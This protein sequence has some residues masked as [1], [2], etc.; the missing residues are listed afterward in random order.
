[1]KFNT[2]IAA[3][4]SLLNET[5]QSG[6]ITREEMRIF[7]L[8]MNPFSPHVTEEVWAN[9]HYNGKMACQ[10]EWPSYDESKCKAASVEIAV[11][12]NGKVRAHLTLDAD[13]SKEDALA[14]AKANDRVNSFLQGKKII[15]EIYVPGKLVNLVAKQ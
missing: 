6:S 5:A 1:L 7:T 2:A 15:K 3:M 8:L 10:Q 11:Q 12:V 14:S 13:V 4:M 9:L